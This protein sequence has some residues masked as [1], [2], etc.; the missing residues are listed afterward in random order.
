MIETGRKD[1]LYRDGEVRYDEDYV[2]IVDPNPYLHVVFLCGDAVRGKF[3]II[4]V[5][6]RLDYDIAEFVMLSSLWLAIVASIILAA[7][8]IFAAW[9]PT[10]TS[11]EESKLTR[12][13]GAI[14]LASWAINALFLLLRLFP[15]GRWWCIQTLSELHLQF[16]LFVYE[17]LLITQTAIHHCEC[18]P[19]ALHTYPWSEMFRAPPSIDGTWMSLLHFLKL[20]GVQSRIVTCVPF[21]EVIWWLKVIFELIK[22]LQVPIQMLHRFLASNS[23]INWICH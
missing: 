12:A 13:T 14:Q 23:C 19:R 8:R 9:N 21:M 4:R 5:L 15:L 7:L 2:W 10:Q 6:V 22:L 20:W 16:W 1:Q 11:V 18:P 3:H 17:A